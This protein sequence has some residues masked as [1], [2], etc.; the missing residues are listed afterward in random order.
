[1]NLYCVRICTRPK[2]KCCV[3]PNTGNF[4]RYAYR[5]IEIFKSIQNT[6]FGCIFLFFFSKPEHGK[7]FLL[8]LLLLLYFVGDQG[9]FVWGYTIIIIIFC[10]KHFSLTVIKHRQ[11]QVY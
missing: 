2:I 3:A 5:S 7:L 10:L 11:L 4:D 8:L 9:S 6:K 1:M